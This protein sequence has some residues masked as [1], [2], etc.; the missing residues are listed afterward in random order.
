M[1]HFNLSE[2]SR[3]MLL[4]AWMKDA[5]SCCEKCGVIPPTSIFQD[6]SSMDHHSE[7]HRELRTP[8]SKHSPKLDVELEVTAIKFQKFKFILYSPTTDVVS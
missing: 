7:E 1:F 3:E 6:L 8:T 5:V 2:W 4:E